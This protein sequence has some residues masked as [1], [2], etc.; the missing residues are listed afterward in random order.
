[1]TS[2][3][4]L[5]RIL[6]GIHRQFQDIPARSE[7]AKATI[8]RVRPWELGRIGQVEDMVHQYLAFADQRELTT[9]ELARLIYPNPLWDR[10]RLR[11]KGEPLPK[12]KSWQYARIRRAAPTFADRVGGGRGRGGFR[13][14]LRDEFYDDVRKRKTARDAARRKA[15]R[16]G[17]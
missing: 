1:M 9:G 10:D 7:R 4:R 16:G 3:D 8:Q 17:S 15:K 13:W 11:D 5:R 12:I 6:Y 2:D 14:R